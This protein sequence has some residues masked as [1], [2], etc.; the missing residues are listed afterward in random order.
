MQLSIAPE[1]AAALAADGTIR[2]LMDVEYQR[3]ES[4]R[5]ASVAFALANDLANEFTAAFLAHLGRTPT[6][7]SSGAAESSTAAAAAGTHNTDNGTAATVQLIFVRL[8]DDRMIVFFDLFLDTCEPQVR[9]QIHEDGFLQ[10][11]HA[12]VQAGDDSYQV[13]R[14]MGLDER[15]AE[16]YMGLQRSV[17]KGPRPYFTD[18][19]IPPAFY[20]AEGYP[21]VPT[22][23]LGFS[24][25]FADFEAESLS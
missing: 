23:L 11:I 16:E 10:P 19:K 4:A 5:T 6:A 12:I 8:R 7:G 15:T 20:D 14:D 17:D 1:S 2:C 22:S 25:T 9:Q 18:N 24:F 3:S 21:V 13:M